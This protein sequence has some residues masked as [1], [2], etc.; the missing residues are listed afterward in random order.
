MIEIKK[1]E[2]RN[3]YD[4]IQIKT[5]EGTFEISYQGNLDLYWR[6]LY[7]GSILKQAETKSFFITKENY[8]IYQLF[9]ELYTNI[10][11]GIPFAKDREKLETNEI[12]QLAPSKEENPNYIDSTLENKHQLLCINNTIDW[13]SDDAEYNKA[14]RVVIQKMPAA[15]Q[16]TFVKSKEDIYNNLFMTFSV[17]FSNSGSR[18]DPFNYNF[19]NMYNKLIDYDLDYHQIHIEEYLYQQKSLK[20]KYQ[21]TP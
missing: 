2:N 10:N 3:G 20:K 12:W 8:F 9:E 16:I 14:S 7:Q 13:H 15:Y 19:M 5:E 17:R 6:Y 11:A 1:L 21:K 4:A 18:Y